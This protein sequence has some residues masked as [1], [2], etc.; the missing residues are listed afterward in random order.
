MWRYSLDKAFLKHTEP[1]QARVRARVT[2]GAPTVPA[3]SYSAVSVGPCRR[4]PDAAVVW[5]R[6]A[7]CSLESTPPRQ[8][9]TSSGSDSCGCW[10]FSSPS[11]KDVAEHFYLQLK[12]KSQFTERMFNIWATNKFAYVSKSSYVDVYG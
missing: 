3:R 6:R 12:T 2:G 10:C 11:Q 1:S 5:T 8:D 9:R 4:W 7:G